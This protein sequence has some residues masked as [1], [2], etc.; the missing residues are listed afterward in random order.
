MSEVEF[1]VG[2]KV[3]W[4][5]GPEWGVG[6]VLKEAYEGR[7]QVRFDKFPLGYV[8]ADDFHEVSFSKLKPYRTL[9][10]KRRDDFEVLEKASRPWREAPDYYKFP[11]GVQTTDISMHLN[12]NGGQAVGYISRSTRID[13][14]N[15]ETDP[16]ESLQKAI[17]LLKMELYR[18]DQALGGSDDSE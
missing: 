14:K 15:K 17:D 5:K 1:K 10:E 13:G 11:N 9:A 2:D 18:L 16:R 6:T 8:S 12:S 4:D 3:V 7:V